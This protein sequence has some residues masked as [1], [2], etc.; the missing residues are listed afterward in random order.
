MSMA[1][2]SATLRSL[3]TGAMAEV[4]SVSSPTDSPPIEAKA[5]LHPTA[6][7]RGQGT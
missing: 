4:S 5:F 1:L 3:R 7:R 2:L 6:E